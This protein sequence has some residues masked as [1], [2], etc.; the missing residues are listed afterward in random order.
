[1]ISIELLTA[2]DT[3][4]KIK[5]DIRVDAMLGYALTG[6]APPPEPALQAKASIVRSAITPAAPPRPAP[7][8]EGPVRE[9]SPEDAEMRISQ[10][11]VTVNGRAES[12]AKS[13]SVSTGALVW[14]SLPNRGRYILLADAPPPLLA[15]L[16][17]GKC[18]EA[19]SPSRLGL[20]RSSWNVP[21][22]SPRETPLIVSMLRTIPNGNLRR[23]L[24]VAIFNTAVLVSES[25]RN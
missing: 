20:R 8:V 24:N 22:P 23:K 9:F 15:F 19:S 5:D 21:R 10:F 11:R 18:G 2:H 25:W 17:R 12:P 14:F 4:Q 1:M 16:K 7:T 13:T 6:T 3:R